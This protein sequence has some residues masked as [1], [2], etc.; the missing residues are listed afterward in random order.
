M[1]ISRIGQERRGADKVTSHDDAD[2]GTRASDLT[3]FGAMV[4]SQGWVST[5]AFEAIADL[6]PDALFFKDREG[7]YLLANHAARAALTGTTS[8]AV[9]GKTDV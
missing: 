6:M 7:R 3:R 4:T 5:P 9:L 1:R 2:L 8:V